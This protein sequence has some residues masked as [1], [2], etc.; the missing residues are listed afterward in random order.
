MTFLHQKPR[1]YA[2]GYI[3]VAPAGLIHELISSH[4]GLTPQAKYVSRLRRFI[5]NITRLTG[6]R[7]R[8]SIRSAIKHV[9][10][11]RSLIER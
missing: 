7:L 5:T 2:R 3:S 10:G 8:P 4:L 1:A 11:A 6:E 9:D